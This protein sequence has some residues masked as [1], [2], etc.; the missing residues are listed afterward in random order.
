MMASLKSAMTTFMMIPPERVGLG[1][2]YD[3]FGL[4]KRVKLAFHQQFEAE[5]IRQ[6][7]ISQRGAV[8]ILMG[9]IP[10]QQYFDKF[11]QTAMSVDGAVAVEVNGVS[12][13]Q[14]FIPQLSNANL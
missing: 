14:P 3:H 10:N 13:F 5:E 11:V 2:E 9:E 1:G 6:L 12:I 7:K 8:V 4:A